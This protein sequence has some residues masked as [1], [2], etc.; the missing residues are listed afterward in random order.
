MI[1]NESSGEDDNHFFK[2]LLMKTMNAT[3]NSQNVHGIKSFKQQ[4]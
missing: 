2:K 3:R 1:K 4:Q